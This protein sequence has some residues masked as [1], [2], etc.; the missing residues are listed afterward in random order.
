MAFYPPGKVVGLNKSLSGL[1]EASRQWHQLLASTLESSGFEH[2]FSDPSVMLRIIRGVV[3]AMAVM[4]VDSLLFGG[5]HSVS[6]GV[7]AALNDVLSR[8]RLG[9][10]V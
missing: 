5:G 9:E 8:K 7:V 3:A 1:K 4:H 10:L 2:S 6:E